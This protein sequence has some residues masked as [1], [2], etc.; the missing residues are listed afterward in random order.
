[1]L[2][3]DAIDF[4]YGFVWFDDTVMQAELEVLSEND[5]D[6]GFFKIESD[7]PMCMKDALDYLI[8]F[9]SEI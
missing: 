4:A 2:K 7:N 1:M 9:E 6:M 5:A 8:H 3:T